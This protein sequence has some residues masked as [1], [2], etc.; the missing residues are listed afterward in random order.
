[1][2][3]GNPESV[4][5]EAN[6]T[7]GWTDITAVV[8][9]E[10]IRGRWG[11]S[12]N[13]AVDLI[14]DTGSLSFLVDNSSDEYIPG[15]TS[16]VAGWDINTAIRLKITFEGVTN[17]VYRAYID[18]LEVLTDPYKK[19][20]RV[21]CV[22]WM[23]YA[24]KHPVVTPT[25]GTSQRADQAIITLVSGMPIAPQA[26]SYETG[27]ET[28]ATVFDAVMPTTRAYSEFT[29]LVNSEFGYLYV[30]KDSTNG[31][32]LFFEDRHYRNGLRSLS[33]ITSPDYFLLLETGDYL[34]LE[35]ADKM[36]LSGQTEN[37]VFDNN[38]TSVQVQYGK[39][40]INRFEAIAY[41]K[42]LAG[43]AEV[44]FNLEKEMVIGAGETIVFRTNYSDSAGGRQIAADSSTMVTPVATTD[45]LMNDTSGGGGGNT[46]ADLTVTAA[47]GTEG[48]TYTLVNGDDV[49]GY[50]TLLQARGK[51]YRA[52][53]PIRAFAKN[54]TSATAYGDKPQT[55]Q[56]RY[57]EKVLL[58]TLQSDAIV[59]YEKNPRLDLQRVSFVANRTSELMYSFLDLDV[60]DLVHIKEDQAEIDGYYYI[61]GVEFSIELGNIIRYS[62][63]LRETL[64]LQKGLTA[65]SFETDRTASQG[66]FFGQVSHVQNLSTMSIAFWMELDSVTAQTR[67]TIANRNNLAGWHIQIGTDILYYFRAMSADNHSQFHDPSFIADTLYHIV[68]THDTS[69]ADTTAPIMYIDGSSVAVGDVGAAPSGSLV[70]ETGATLVLGNVLY[71]GGDFP[72]EGRIYDARI[73]NTILTSG[74]VTTLYNGG[75]P[76]PSL[77]TTGLKFQSPVVKTANTTDYVGQTLTTDQRLMDNI[78][79]IV[80]TPKEGVVGRT[81]LS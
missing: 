80:G 50:I 38:M 4:V 59:N 36:V 19:Y 22:D 47:Y 71:A 1:M 70:D 68:I 60:G 21:Y 37:A 57:Q 6:I 31:E 48:V 65:I 42:E 66:V 17:I 23:D 9:V 40:I 78:Y 8:V 30:K 61:Q 62:W 64:S 15:H 56:Q 34:L 54:A 41:P 25:V 11:M 18:R 10:P 69:G 53:S 16:A 7:A 5:V 72:F 13:T 73:Y 26:T 12:D 39:D 45:Y 3:T 27:Q 75:V 46:T 32:Q 33:T 51:G 79:G 35:T 63:I 24:A 43:A 74:N 44:L 28:Y 2:T 55:F 76:D 14:A 77:L 49:T 52:Y 20:V 81:A 67:T 58:G 29:K